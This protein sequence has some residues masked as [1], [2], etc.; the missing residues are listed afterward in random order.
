MIQLLDNIEK[1]ILNFA[2]LTVDVV[3]LNNKRFEYFTTVNEKYNEATYVALN[4]KIIDFIKWLNNV[5]NSIN[6]NNNI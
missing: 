4:L 6:N 5:E 3:T 1:L 2:K